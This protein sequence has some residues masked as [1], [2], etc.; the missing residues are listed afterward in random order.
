MIGKTIN[1]Q[2]KIIYLLGGGGFGRAYLAQDIKSSTK[3]WCVVKQFQPSINPINPVNLETAKR[4]FYTEAE[5]L[6]IL[7]KH[8]R[9]PQLLNFFEEEKQLYLVED[10]VEG[11]EFS[12]ELENS[13]FSEKQIYNF[14]LDI[15]EII[16][17][18]QDNNVIHRDI[19]PDNLVKRKLDN[20]LV[21]IDFGAVKQVL[22]DSNGRRRQTKT[23]IIGKEDY[24]P[25]EQANGRP[26]FYSDVYAV[27]VI[28]IQAC[29][30]NIPS[31]DYETGEIIWR[32]MAHISPELADILD[33]M[34]SCYFKHRY[35]SASEVITDLKQLSTNYR[36]LETV[37][38]NYFKYN[39]SQKWYLRGNYLKNR[40][41]HEE[42][43]LLYKKVLEINPKHFNAIFNIGIAYSYLK[44]YDAAINTYDL[45]LNIKPDS[46]V[47]LLHKGIILYKLNLY[48]E[49]IITFEILIHRQSSQAV[50]LFYKAL[51]LQK[52]NR[53][54]EASYYYQEAIKLRPFFTNLIN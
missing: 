26:G 31:R 33:R 51:T 47:T 46:V 38:P 34:T 16:K 13:R 29:I 49:A 28:G 54:E 42:A 24:M 23:I 11:Y 35:Q 25:D 21:L 48:E 32:N 10:F 22:I 44:D 40:K 15:L 41:H 19:S 7:G 36:N 37:E 30:G 20:K 5:A 3:L 1:E 8:D 2:Y 18:I 45:L 52:L 4:L 53:L 27:G 43:I 14:L 9:I 12:E 17:F 6:K 39:Y 50:T